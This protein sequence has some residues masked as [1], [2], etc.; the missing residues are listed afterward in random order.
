[1]R[2]P[3]DNFE[4]TWVGFKP[5]LNQFSY[6]WHMAQTNFYVIEIRFLLNNS[7]YHLTVHPKSGFIFASETRRKAWYL[8]IS[9]NQE[10]QSS[11]TWA[12]ANRSSRLEVFCR[13]VFLKIWQ[14]LQGN[15]CVGVCFLVKIQTLQLY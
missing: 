13:K 6:L 4:L 2:N 5:I 12:D 9:C 15:T 7:W 10:V 1:M 11:I 3:F 14:N 8:S